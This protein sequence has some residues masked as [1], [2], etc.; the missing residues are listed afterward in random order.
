MQKKTEKKK[1]YQ[2]ISKLLNLGFKE[3]KIYAFIG[4]LMNLIM[5]VVIVIII[6]YG[7]M[8][9]ASNTMSTGELVAF[10]LYLFQII[11]PITSFAM[12]FYQS[13]KSKRSN[14]TDY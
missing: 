9:V 12:F 13:P 3:A 10:L 7:G 4:P 5:M 2:G 1:G 8:R 11:M 6:S 14:R